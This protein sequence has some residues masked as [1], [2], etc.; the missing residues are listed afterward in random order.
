VETKVA[1][2]FDGDKVFFFRSK[3]GT[4]Y[5]GG[6]I[7]SL[8]P[9]TFSVKFTPNILLG[10]CARGNGRSLLGEILSQSAQVTIRSDREV[11]GGQ[12]CYVIEALE[13]DK[14]PGITYNTR[15]W[16][17]PQRGFR[18]VKVETYENRIEGD[19]WAILRQRVEVTR[20]EEIGGMWVPL[21]GIRSYY[22][23]EPGS[24]AASRPAGAED[25]PIKEK[26]RLGILSLRESPPRTK[27]VV[28]RDS[29]KL[30]NE[31]P[32][33]SFV[34]EFPRGTRVWDAIVGIGYQVGDPPQ[35]LEEALETAESTGS[36]NDIAGNK[37]QTQAMGDH[38]RQA[39]SPGPASGHVKTDEQG[40]RWPT[41]VAIAM[42]VAAIFALALLAKRHA[43]GTRKEHET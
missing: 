17:D 12:S 21:E 33:S 18:P 26:L 22:V 27:L 20:M 37:A 40:V 30:N 24:D 14:Y 7:R 35:S 19:P 23:L 16:I 3:A 13:T 2:A 4:N 5:L 10:S 29:M 1:T 42:G 39:T 31:I 41:W 43:A 34:I 11:I 28:G 38:G 32:A 9:S 6:A 15:A 8:N 36:I 25:L